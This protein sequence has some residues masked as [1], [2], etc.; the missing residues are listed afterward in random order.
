MSEFSEALNEAIVQSG[1]KAELIEKLAGIRKSTLAKY[2]NGERFPQEEDTV[3]NI[4]KVVQCS[5][6]KKN[7][8]ME[9]WRKKH[10]A[11]YFGNSDAWECIKEIMNL[12]SR[13]IEISQDE[14]SKD[15]PTFSGFN[16]TVLYGKID[17]KKHLESMLEQMKKD[18]KIFIWGNG[19]LIN[20]FTFFEDKITV[21]CYHVI[22]LSGQNRESQ[23]L[24]VACWAL[25]LM[26]VQS[27]YH[28][29]LSY[30][31]NGWLDSLL[32]GVIFSKKVAVFLMK[33]MERSIVIDNPEQLEV[34]HYYFEEA[35]RIGKLIAVSIPDDRAEFEPE[36]EAYYLTDRVVVDRF[37]K[38]KGVQYVTDS[39]IK[40][41]AEQGEFWDV[42]K[43]VLGNYRTASGRKSAL[44][45][46][47]AE[48]R[49]DISIHLIDNRKILAWPG[50][51]IVA[52]QVAPQGY[53]ARI[54]VQKG[55]ENVCFE[56]CET[57]ILKWIYRVLKDLKKSESVFT[58]EKQQ[59]MISSAIQIARGEM[60]RGNV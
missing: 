48:D 53:C 38:R 14:L 31:G 9:N 56:I 49:Q 8:I 6:N 46:I 22:H 52:W 57:Q 16:S 42:H 41:L 55:L 19:D 2:R 11:D 7:H 20:E 54:L 10:Y 35:Y 12:I 3:R 40:C 44:E 39:S 32:T 17:V 1:E 45:Q 15:M 27:Q 24:H 13:K 59:E 18:G 50:I 30:A 47:L 29:V 58:A 34:I 43:N 33:D 26:M 23:Q 25:S 5:E 36:E 28:P 4:L 37:E 21:P 51:Q 60:E